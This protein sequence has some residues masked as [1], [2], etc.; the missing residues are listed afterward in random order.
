MTIWGTIITGPATVLPAFGP[1]IGVDITGDLVQQAGGDVVSVVKAIAGLAGTAMTI[2]GRIR[3]T[4]PLM[5]RS[6]LKI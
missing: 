1:L 6:N 5:L 2:F 3:A 4:R